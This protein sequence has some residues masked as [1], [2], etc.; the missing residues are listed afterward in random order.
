MT[1]HRWTAAALGV[2]MLALAAPARAQSLAELSGTMATQS[3]LNAGAAS[4]ASTAHAAMTSVI[5]NLPQSST[6]LPIPQSA[7]AS[8][9]P[10]GGGTSKWASRGSGSQSGTTGHAWAT[11]SSTTGGT[12]TSKGWL[13]ASSTGGWLTASSGGSGGGAQS[14]W[15]RATDQTSRA[16]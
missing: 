6:G 4:G 15:L 7:P 9:A 13:T 12:P 10:S 1:I 16:R 5:R 11:K 2:A 3:A 14:G 8:H